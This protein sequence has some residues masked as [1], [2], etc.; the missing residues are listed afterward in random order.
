MAVLRSEFKATYCR[1][2]GLRAGH[3]IANSLGSSR[4][5]QACRSLVMLSGRG[6]RASAVRRLVPSARAVPGLLASNICPARAG[7]R[8]LRFV[9]F[10]SALRPLP[11][12]GKV[13]AP[14]VVSRHNYVFSRTAGDSAV[15]NRS[16]SAAAG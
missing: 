8:P 10:A 6:P 2:S 14:S 13:A 1:A 3:A 12:G 7:A 11:R 5:A 15:L 4:A 9:V 16:M